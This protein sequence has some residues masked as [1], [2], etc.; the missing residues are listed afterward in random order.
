[1]KRATVTLRKKT[2][3]LVNFKEF[4]WTRSEPVFF[5][6]PEPDFKLGTLEPEL[7]YEPDFTKNYKINREY[8]NSFQHISH[9]KFL[10]SHSS[11]EP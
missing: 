5:N 11:N 6:K 1:M 9:N 2:I 10:S 8:E 7:E 3:L 4:G